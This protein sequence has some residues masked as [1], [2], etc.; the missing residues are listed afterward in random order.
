MTGY[1]YE[2]Q[3]VP[4]RGLAHLNAQTLGTLFTGTPKPFE[5]ERVVGEAAEVPVE[6]QIYRSTFDGSVAEEH[7][8]VAMGGQA[9]Q[10]ATVLKEHYSDRM[11]LAG[12][13]AAAIA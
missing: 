12:A 3:A 9:E 11:S 7:G 1:Q 10:V 8:Y 13:L 2:S 6:D 5:V 4:A